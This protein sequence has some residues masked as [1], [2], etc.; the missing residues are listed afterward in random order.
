MEQ[1]VISVQLEEFNF[2]MA[3]IPTS[4][5]HKDQKQRALSKNLI[6]KMKRLIPEDQGREK[7]INEAV[8]ATCAALIWGKGISQDALRFARA[9]D[10]DNNAPTKTLIKTWRFGQKMR[11]F[12]SFSDVRAAS[13]IHQVSS[14]S[15]TNNNSS[16]G[17]P[18]LLR[19]DSLY[20]GADE[21]IVNKAAVKVISLAGYL[22][23]LEPPANVANLKLQAAAKLTLAR[24]TSFN[25]DRWKR[26][27]SELQSQSKLSQMMEVRRNCERGGCEVIFI[28]ARRGKSICARACGRALALA[29]ALA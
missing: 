1:N 16:G 3:F 26:T 23:A 4:D 20:E 25:T 15:T 14:S 24:Q 17:P 8:Y 19:G 13:L 21:K 18:T 28:E 2:L 7:S 6:S 11:H 27:V 29:L 5:Q 9:D 22:I 12:F 10:D